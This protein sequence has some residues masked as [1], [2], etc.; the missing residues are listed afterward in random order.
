MNLGLKDLMEKMMSDKYLTIV[1]VSFFVF[2][3]LVV[4]HVQ[5]TKQIEAA[6]ELAKINGCKPRVSE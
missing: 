4:K 1:I 5:T 2:I 6:V 3:A